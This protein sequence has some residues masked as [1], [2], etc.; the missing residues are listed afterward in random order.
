MGRA[1][2]NPPFGEAFG[3]HHALQLAVST[4]FRS[5]APMCPETLAAALISQYPGSGMI[6]AEVR[7]AIT[8][9]AD[10]ANVPIRHAPEPPRGVV[11]FPAGQS[12]N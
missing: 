11:S 6:E 12:L 1:I 9:A 10:A 8:R 5:G 4:A 7:A 2:S 3:F